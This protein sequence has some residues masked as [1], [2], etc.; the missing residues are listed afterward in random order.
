MLNPF[1]MYVSA[2]GILILLGRCSPQ[3]A[4]T[5]LVSYNLNTPNKT[6]KLPATLREISGMLLKFTFFHLSKLGHEFYEFSR[7]LISTFVKI[8]KI[9]VPFHQTISIDLPNFKS[10]FIETSP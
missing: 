2:I 7:I 4:V 3:K 6:F 8:R 9:R 10:M 5:P 1:S